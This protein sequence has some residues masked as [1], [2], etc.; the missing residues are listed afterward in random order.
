M[1]W[2]L[3]TPGLLIVTVAYYLGFDIPSYQFS[4]RDELERKL[5]ILT[6]MG[7]ASE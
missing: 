1:F 3:W 5:P 4:S 2:I 6:V 7:M